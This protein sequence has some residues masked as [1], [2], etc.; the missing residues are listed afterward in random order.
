MAS[1]LSNLLDLIRHPME[2]RTLAQYSVYHEPRR[3]ITS[4]L[5]LATTRYNE[6]TMRKCWDMLDATAGL[7]A[8]TVK[9]L[10]N[11]LARV[12][13]VA[14]HVFRAL[15]L[16]EGSTSLSNDAKE[17]S[18]R[19]FHQKITKSTATFD[20]KELVD[21]DA[22]VAE[23]A[24]LPADCR[25]IIINT[26]QQMG[27][28]MADYIHRAAAAARKGTSVACTTNTVEYDL[29]CHYTSGLVGEAL[30]KFFVLIPAPVRFSSLPRKD[31]GVV[32]IER[33]F[34]GEQAL[35]S[36]SCALLV[37][38]AT[39]IQNVV[40]DAKRGV[41][42]WP[43]EVVARGGVRNLEELLANGSG[44]GEAAESALWVLSE[45]VLGALGHATDALDYIVLLK[46]Q[47][48]FNLVAFSTALA[49]ATLDL[50]YMNPKVFTGEAELRKADPVKLLMRST[51]PHTVAY[52]FLDYAR[53]I[54]ARATPRD[55]HFL[56]ISVM[57]GKIETWVEHHFPSY[58]TFASGSRTVFYDDTDPRSRIVK[59]D[60]A[61][62]EEKARAERQ[63]KRDAEMRAWIEKQGVKPREGAAADVQLYMADGSPLMLYLL[64]IGALILF[65]SVGIAISIGGLWYFYGDEWVWKDEGDDVGIRAIFRK[66]FGTWGGSSPIDPL[67]V[68]R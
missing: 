12:V 17:S 14:Y 53:R 33:A 4:P 43:N 57:C 18:L 45:M 68:Q 3:D 38:K 67:K 5:E 13:C 37:K 59:R 6:P 39:L 16:I 10:D 9:G 24:L 58:I 36:N 7:Y 65:L 2:Y 48:T 63:L 60:K 61:Q 52:F 66:V 51:D 28:G 50:C 1:Y 47:G 40:E 54:H 55:P 21:F 56:A 41:W 8:V 49:L 30:T 31:T 25:T 64:L 23:L 62:D 27:A 34:L 29:Y 20:E 11:D 19:G 44:E 22:V 15:Y 46:N 42:L 32:M 26:A 35:L